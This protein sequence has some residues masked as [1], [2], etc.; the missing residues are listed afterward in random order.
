MAATQDVTGKKY[1]YTMN[2]WDAFLYTVDGEYFAKADALSESSVSLTTEMQE[3]RGGSANLALFSIPTSKE[4]SISLTNLDFDEKRIALQTGEKFNLG[5]FV[6]E[7][8]T[9]SCEVANGKIEL[10][11]EPVGKHV[12]LDND[13]ETIAIAVAA[14]DAKMVSVADYAKD[15]DCVSVV[16]AAEVPSA[17]LEMGRDTAPAIIKLVMNKKVYNGE[18]GAH[19]KTITLTVN[20]FQLDG[21]IEFAGTMGDSDTIA[22]NGKA[23][24]SK[25]SRCSDGKLSLAVLNVEEVAGDSMKVDKIAL[26]ENFELKVG[27]TEQIM[28][29]GVKNSMTT[30][31]PFDVTKDCS[32]ESSDKAIVT[33][34]AAGALEAK[35]TTTEPITVTVTYNEDATITATAKVTV[36]E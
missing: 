20:R 18:T 27:D 30:F 34:S 7:G 10:P 28:V 36:T 29:S 8:R 21:N 12:Y 2:A 24:A 31:M 14:E 1:N 3:K 15:G 22:L 35:A 5:R 17:Q 23:L 26:K 13:G 11:E 32:F 25:S 9:A 16:Y 19:V 4:L 33:V 6:V